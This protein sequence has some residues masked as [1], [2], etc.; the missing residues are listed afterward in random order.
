MSFTVSDR[1]DRM[2]SAGNLDG[3]LAEQGMRKPKLAFFQ[4]RYDNTVPAFLLRHVHEHVKCLSQF[5]D[6]TVIDQDCDF[7][8]ICDSIE[9]ELALFESGTNLCNTRRLEI[10]GVEKEHAIPKLGLLNCDA[11]SEM[12]AGALSELDRWGVENFVSIAVTAAEHMPA[13]AH[14][15]FVWPNF[16]DTDV[17]RN[18]GHPKVIPILI[19]GAQASQY[20]WR[21]EVTRAVSQ[22]FPTLVWPHPGYY[23]TAD[24]VVIYGKEYAKTINAASIVPTCGTVAKEVVRKHFEIPACHTCLVTEASPGLVA[25]GYVDMV[26][27]VF[28]NE[29][30]V[31]EKLH[32][33]FRHPDELEAISHAGYEL[34]HARHTMQQRDQILQWLRV[35]RRLGVGERIAQPNPFGPPK[36]ILAGEQSYAAFSVSGG[37]HLACI[38]EGD[39]L[40]T[41][42][43]ADAA[44]Q[45][46]LKCLSYTRMLPE[47]RL[48]VGIT[49]LFKGNA[50]RAF[51]WFAAP[52][53]C[54]LAGYK[55]PEPD[56]VEWA[57]LIVSLVCL[58]RMRWAAIASNQFP[59]LQH[60]ELERVRVVVAVLTGKRDRLTPACVHPMAHRHSVHRLPERSGSE[61]LE[62]LR[63]MLRACGQREFA[64]ALSDDCLD[65][66]SVD[67]KQLR[68]GRPSP[69]TAVSARRAN[70]AIGYFVLR[71]KLLTLR[72]RVFGAGRYLR[73]SSAPQRVPNE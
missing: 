44:E 56:P 2:D 67:V 25:A 50:K 39:R 60:K 24:Q 45:L 47:A 41:S 6:V 31:V 30:D 26:N 57:Y 38:R 16:V 19:T 53:Q 64:E 63:Q 66:H 51:S 73:H 10:K 21:R 37:L 36:A 14:R 23:A 72:C 18:Y 7:R 9:P 5:F 48:R 28:A 58:G 49:A 29:T 62:Q 3:L 22:R 32:H 46:Y 4:R 27:C 33:L 69:A 55:A 52:I 68:N 42:G 71:Q 59:R 1:T 17:Y 13:I 35:Y 43:Q 65:R 40:L 54:T 12:R 8:Q 11:W 70:A 15:L 20:P 34:V 61:W